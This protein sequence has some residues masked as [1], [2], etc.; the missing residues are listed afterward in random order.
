MTRSGTSPTLSRVLLAHGSG[1]R[2]DGVD[3]GGVGV[4]FYVLIS[5]C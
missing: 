2:A 4:D 1:P 5:I 3:G